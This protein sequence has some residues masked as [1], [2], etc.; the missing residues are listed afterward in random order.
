MLK[1]NDIGSRISYDST[2]THNGITYASLFGAGCYVKLGPTSFLTEN[3]LASTIGHEWVHWS[4][5]V[6]F[7]PSHF[8]ENGPY[9]WEIMNMSATG[10]KRSDIN[11]SFSAAWVI[12]KP[13]E[14]V[15]DIPWTGQ[16]YIDN[17]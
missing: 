7:G 8:E 11:L 2:I 16:E 17:D 15:Q 13:N 4:N 14:T 1:L 5:N 9:Y 3:Q 12:E 10:A 6:F